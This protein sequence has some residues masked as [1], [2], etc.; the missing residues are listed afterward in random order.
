MIRIILIVIIT[1]PSE[2]QEPHKKVTKSHDNKNFLFF[3]FAERECCQGLQQHNKRPFRR[4]F[5]DGKTKCGHYR[6]TF[7]NSS[8]SVVFLHQQEKFKVN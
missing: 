5:C 3:V 8:P 6:R 1:K 2:I 7:Q 4:I